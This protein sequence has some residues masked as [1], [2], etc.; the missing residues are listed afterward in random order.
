MLLSGCEKKS[1]MI[2]I[3]NELL[4]TQTPDLNISIK[5]EKDASIF[6]LSV[7]EN[8]EKCNANLKSIKELNEWN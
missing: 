2:K 1:V 7:L 4:K 8:L 6:W 3:P 5:S